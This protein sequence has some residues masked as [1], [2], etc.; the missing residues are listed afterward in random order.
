MPGT[1]QEDQNLIHVVSSVK[2][3][4]HGL[5]EGVF[6]QVEVVFGLAAFEIAGTDQIYLGSGQVEVKNGGFTACHQLFLDHY[7]TL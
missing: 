7:L 2:F 6:A 3:G 4:V 1:N 5:I